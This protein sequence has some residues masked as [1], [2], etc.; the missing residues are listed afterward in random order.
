MVL[1]KEPESSNIAI[2]GTGISNDANHIAGPSRTG[3]GLIKAVR[4]AMHEADATTVD[5]ISAHGTATLFNDEMEAQ[6][7]HTL[8]MQDVPLMSAKGYWGH[9]LGAAGIVELIAL[10]NSMRSGQL[11]ASVGYHE[12]GLTLPL[13]IV[14]QTRAADLNS[15]LK[16]SSGFGG[17]NSAV[18][19]QRT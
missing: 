17:S 15:C 2:T 9:T 13:N 16:T 1:T 4:A 14:T 18:I 11:F 3:A 7:F 8:G 6:A 5:H 10:V 19:L 12:N